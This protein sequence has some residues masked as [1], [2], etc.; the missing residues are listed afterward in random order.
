M[1][2]LA[3]GDRFEDGGGFQLI[4][5][6]LVVRGRAHVEGQRVIGLH[7]V[8]V[9]VP[10]GDR[11]HRLRIAQGTGA[12]IERLEIGVEDADRPNQILFACG[13]GAQLRGFLDSRSPFEQVLGRRG[14]ERVGQQALRD[15]PIG[16]CAFA[17]GAERLLEAGLR[18]A[19]PERML[20]SHAAIEVGLRRRVA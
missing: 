16:D 10:A 7:L 14:I 2:R 9:R 13:A 1:I 20:V 3:P 19:I 6:A 5:V 8:V 17:I 18:F 11:F 12:L 4:R 15:A